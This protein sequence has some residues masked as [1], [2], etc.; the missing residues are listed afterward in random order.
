MRRRTIKIAAAL[1]AFTLCMGALGC[2]AGEPLP[3]GFDADAVTQKAADIVA[4]AT[5][6]D[7]DAIIASMRED[8]QG[9]VTA[10]QLEESWSAI[11]E[12]AGAFESIT[13]TVLSGTAD[14]STGE[15]YAV[16]QVLVKHENATL[17]YTLSFDSDLAL[18]GL[19][20]K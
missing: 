1:L 13:K 7:Y 2:S 17:L 3:E 9:A 4:L 20:L 16:A 15:E 8:L 11:Y 6:G 14:Q 18:V 19:Y 12:N 5:G 10:E